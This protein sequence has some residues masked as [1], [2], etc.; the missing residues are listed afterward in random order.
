MEIYYP[1][2]TYSLRVF[3]AVASL[4]VS[5]NAVLGKYPNHPN[6]KWNPFGVIFGESIWTSLGLGVQE[7]ILYGLCLLLLVLSFW[8]GRTR[9]DFD[10]SAI[11]TQSNQ[12]IGVQSID[13]R[14]ISANSNHVTSEIVRGILGGQETQQAEAVHSA[15]DTLG[16][17]DVGDITKPPER[18]EIPVSES[19]FNQPEQIPLPSAQVP[20]EDVVSVPLPKANSKVDTEDSIT[21]PSMLDLPLSE[22]NAVGE[23]IPELPTL[24]D[25]DFDS[26]ESDL[27]DLP[28]V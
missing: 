12:E 22:S 20:A 6:M 13:L 14:S 15:L 8:T 17:I 1:K 3:V 24:P 21:L 28:E 27:P 23:E 4:F 19:S 18:P 7:Y 25:F 16:Q 26:K 10:V 2:T 5:I 11:S 9:P